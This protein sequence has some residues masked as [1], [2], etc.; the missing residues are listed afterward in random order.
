MKRCHNKRHNHVLMM[1]R[2]CALKGLIR[3][4]GYTVGEPIFSL[5]EVTGL[6]SA[7]TSKQFLTSLEE[8]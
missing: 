8:L 5:H 6:T 7:D 3:E 1:C 4:S 2:N